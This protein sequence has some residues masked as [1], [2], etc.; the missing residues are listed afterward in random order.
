MFDMFVYKIER[1]ILVFGGL[2]ETFG[3]NGKG[4][5][6][7]CRCDDIMWLGFMEGTS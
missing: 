1:V 4:V 3:I 5:A 2:C 7:F 6:C